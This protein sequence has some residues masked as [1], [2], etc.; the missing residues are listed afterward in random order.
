ME[1]GFNLEIPD[2]TGLKPMHIA[3][4]SGSLEMVQMLIDSFP[5]FDPSDLTDDRSTIFH[6]AVQN[7]DVQVTKMIFEKHNFTFNN[8]TNDTGMTMLH[9]A[10]AL[11]PQNTIVFLL[12][13]YL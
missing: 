7:P 13:K 6:F 1:C 9:N 8:S 5:M 3:C 11:G 10:V 4:R 2:P 12:D